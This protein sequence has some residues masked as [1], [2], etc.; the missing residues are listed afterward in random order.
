MIGFLINKFRGND[1]LL[2]PAI[3]SVEKITSRKIL[4]VIPKV[5][6]NLPDEDSLMVKIPINLD[7]LKRIMG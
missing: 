2:D 6:F 7:L 3:K 4:G 5:D 1:S